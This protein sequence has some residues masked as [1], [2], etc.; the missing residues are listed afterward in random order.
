MF[1]YV[2]FS[3][4]RL[5]CC[6]FGL[7]SCSARFNFEKCC[8]ASSSEWSVEEWRRAQILRE[9]T[10]P[11]VQVN[12]FGKAS[13]NPLLLLFCLHTQNSFK[14]NQAMLSPAVTTAAV[15]KL[16]YRAAHNPS[17]S[18]HH[19]HHQKKVQ[20]GRI[21][22]GSGKA[23]VSSSIAGKQNVKVCKVCAY[24]CVLVRKCVFLEVKATDFNLSTKALNVCKGLTL[25]VI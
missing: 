16:Q 6:V 13:L 4:V 1:T 15:S 20:N 17:N 23:A 11:C 14:L 5:L 21:I 18:N 9:Y 7:F 25:F 24:T 12:L 2:K 8:L 10:Y 22:K 19:H 3:F